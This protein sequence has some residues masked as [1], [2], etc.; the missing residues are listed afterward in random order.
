M[1]EAQVRAQLAGVTY[2]AAIGRYSALRQAFIS[3]Y[4]QALGETNNNLAMKYIQEF[5]DEINGNDQSSNQA[6]VWSLTNSLAKKIEEA[7]AGEMDGTVRGKLASL[8]EDFS[9][10]YGDLSATAKSL[11]KEQVNLL[12]NIDEFHQF[13]E[14]QI[15]SI[16]PTDSEGG[17]TTT[18]LLN[19][20]KSGLAQNLYYSQI[21]AKAT[22]QRGSIAGY[23]LEALVHG[24]TSKLT[25]HL[26]SK[27]PGAQ[28]VGSTKIVIPVMGGKATSKVDTIFDEYFN[29]FSSDLSGEFESSIDVTGRGL[30]Q[31][32]FGA[33]VKL[34]N[35]PWKNARPSLSKKI[36]SN[37]NLYAAWGDKKSWIKGV[38]F[39]E[40]RVQQI[41]GDN[42]MYILG[43][44]FYWTA[45]FLT[46]MRENDYY[47]AFH[48]NGESFTG[49]IVMEAID[50]SKPF[51]S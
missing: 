16:V 23:F 32:G 22:V 37:S 15:T 3:Q 18:D 44:F 50:M 2:S 24:A 40:T 43:N 36:G 12:F 17:T 28:M 7:V 31:Y 27:L 6:K 29:F 45:D 41:F 33:Q 39:L 20:I 11:L 47:L 46:E 10:K 8:S 30:G 25:S 48:H 26:S 14:K 21:N 42:V 38:L 9:K 35:P 4:S 13:L 51:S 19:S 34:W 5:I 49:D 1:T